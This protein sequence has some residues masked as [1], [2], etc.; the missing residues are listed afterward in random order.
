KHQHFILYKPDGYISQFITN[1]R[2][3]HKKRL[4]GE[5]Y[6]FPKKTMA[7]GRLDEDSEGLLLL[8]TDGKF[9]NYINSSSIEKEYYAQVDGII[10]PQEIAIL[11]EGL[12][13]SHRGKK[14]ITKPCKSRL[15]SS[16]DLPEKRKKNKRR[17]S[18]TNVLD[19][20][21][22]DRRKISTSQK[23]DCSSRISHI[24]INQS[25]SRKLRNKK[26]AS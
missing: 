15:I 19:F 17:P 8:T 9:S 5:F 24:K 13:L 23:N 3:G 6:D 11:K 10:S 21:H 4:L 12:T 20:Y 2:R 22:F 18:R 14:Y 7:I 16:P 1:Q 26:H 25:E